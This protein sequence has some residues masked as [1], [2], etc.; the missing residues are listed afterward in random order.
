MH[1]LQGLSISTAFVHTSRLTVTHVTSAYHADIAHDKDNTLL[2]VHAC[3]QS[4]TVGCFSMIMIACIVCVSYLTHL[5]LCERVLQ[6]D[7]SV[8]HVRVLRSGVLLM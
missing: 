8:L 4:Q 3:A 1:F 6:I 5:V 7:V 2:E